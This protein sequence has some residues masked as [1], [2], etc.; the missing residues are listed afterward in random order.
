MPGGF[1]GV[2]IFFVI[3]GYLI[4][5]LL[6]SEQQRMGRISLRRFWIRRARRLLPALY[7]L[8]MAVGDRH[9]AVHPRRDGQDARRVPGRPLVH[10][11]LVPDRHRHVVLRQPRPA[12]LLRHLWSLAVEEQFYILWPIIVAVCL[13]V[14]RNRL[15][16]IAAVFV[17]MAVASTVLMAL[18]FDAGDPSRAYYGTDTRAA[19]LILGATLALFWRPGHLARGK[20]GERGPLVDLVGVARP[21]H[22]DA[23]L[24]QG[25]RPGAVALPGRVLRGGPGQPGGDRRRRPS[26]LAAGARAR[27]R[28]AAMDRDALLRHLSVA[29]AGVRAH[30]ARRRRREP[31]PGSRLRAALRHHPRPHRAHVPAGGDPCPQGGTG[32]VVPRPAH[33]QPGAAPPPP[34]RHGLGD[35]GHGADHRPAR[36]RHGEGQAHHQRHPAEHPGGRGGRR[37]QPDHARVAR[38]RLRAGAGAATPPPPPPRRRPPTRPPPPPRRVDPARRRARGHHGRRPTRR[39]PLPRPPRRRRPPRSTPSPSA[40]R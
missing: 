27:S 31:Q 19:G 6:V 26:A 4:T 10:H 30:R 8:L 40:T 24:P 17:S 37:R 11:Q 25:H 13:R 28:P 21:G 23:V 32:R 18:T 16:R 12:S 22:A 39:R 5:L 3:S 2:E 20:I 33:P 36:L 9:R 15:D 38:S 1:L 34:A 29:L 35:G 14:C 7:C